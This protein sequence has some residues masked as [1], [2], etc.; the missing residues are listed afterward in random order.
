MKKKPLHYVLNGVAVLAAIFQLIPIYILLM[1]SFK[2]PNDFSSRWL[3]PT[4]L[5][6]QNYVSI[7]KKSSLFQSFFN[8]ILVTVG[9]VV[10]VLFCGAICAY[11]ISRIKSKVSALITNMVLAVMMIPSLSV[12]VPLYSIM[13]K[14]KAINTYWGIILVLAAY[15]LPMSVFLFSNFIRNISEEMDEAASI[16]GCNDWRIFFSVIL[17][18][19]TPIVASVLILT[20]I[21]IW[22]DYKYALY[23]LQKRKFETITLFISKFFSDFSADLNAAAASAVLAILPACILF[24]CLQKYFISGISEGSIK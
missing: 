14:L 5:N 12:I 8:S 7:L 22:N 24:L 9:A 17:P 3:P 6:F 1:V 15:N 13:L 20:G 23:F 11:P 19:L 21:K 16:D 10:L 2:K 4:Y 18:Q